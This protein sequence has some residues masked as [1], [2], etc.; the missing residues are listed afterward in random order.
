[1]KLNYKR[2]FLVGLAFL[3]I[4]AFWQ[5]YDGVIPKILTNTF[6]L[7]ESVSGILMAAD[8]L[9]GLLLLP[10]FGSLSD[11]CSARLGRRMPF[12]LAGTAGA[13]ILM[14][15]L[16]IFDNRFAA[17]PARG[18]SG[19]FWACCCACWCAW[20]PIAHPPWP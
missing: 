6:H 16:P 7:G 17:A 20:P 3:S 10:L 15:L 14:N 19:P 13:V 8:N 11:R 9:L 12:I 5:M 18:Y 2:T 1:M 4:S